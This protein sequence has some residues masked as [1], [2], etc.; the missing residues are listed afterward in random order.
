MKTEEVG[1]VYRICRFLIFFGINS[2]LFSE[3]TSSGGNKESVYQ[4]E[5]VEWEK[6]LKEARE[7]V[8]FFIGR[9][10]SILLICHIS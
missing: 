1:C 8:G 5:M 4:E 9:K 6:E 10:S 2:V 3:M 7:Q